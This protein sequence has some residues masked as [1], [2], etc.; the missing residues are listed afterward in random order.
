MS[1]TKA[2]AQR[3]CEHWARFIGLGFHPDTRGADYTPPMTRAQIRNYDANMRA[4]SQYD[5]DYY[6]IAVQALESTGVISH[7]E[8][9]Q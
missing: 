2:S 4:L 6:A 8:S 1:I 7:L 5:G 3:I 9:N